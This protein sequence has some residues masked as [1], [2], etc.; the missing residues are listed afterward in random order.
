MVRRFVKLA[1]MSVIFAL[2]SC[3]DRDEVVVDVDAEM[4]QRIAEAMDDIQVIS[5]EEFRVQLIT[6][7]ADESNN[8]HLAGLFPAGSSHINVF[9][10]GKL[11]LSVLP[12]APD[13]SYLI[14]LWNPVEE[15]MVAVLETNAITGVPAKISYSGT[16]KEGVFFDTSD[17]NWDGQPDTILG[18]EDGPTR[19][20]LQDRW[21]EVVKKEGS[22][23]V[24]IGGSWKKIARDKESNEYEFSD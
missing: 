22:L 24:V 17:R 19:I 11:F 4:A 9:R 5:N 14:G 13:G 7:D 12:E 18:G 2:S 21:Q 15:K 23:G 3:S 6:F 8:P 20:W 1:S 10:E 16:S